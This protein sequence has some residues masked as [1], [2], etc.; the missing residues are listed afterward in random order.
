MRESSDD[1]GTS[2][3][4]V[5][6]PPKDLRCQRNDGKKWRCRDWRIH[7]QPYC[8]KHY[9]QLLKKSTV[10]KQNSSVSASNPTRVIKERSGNPKGDA[11]PVHKSGKSGLSGST[12]NRRGRVRA[13]DDEESSK[14]DEHPLK[15]QRTQKIERDISEDNSDKY[16]KN[17]KC[18]EEG[19]ENDAAFEEDVSLAK[20]WK[21]KGV[22]TKARAMDSSIM[23]K[24]GA[25]GSEDDAKDGK[26]ENLAGRSNKELKKRSE[27]SGKKE[28]SRKGKDKVE[29]KDG[30]ALG[31]DVDY[32]FRGMG[33]SSCKSESSLKSKN[34]KL[35]VKKMEVKGSEEDNFG[36]RQ[37]KKSKKSVEMELGIREKN[38]GLKGKPES[39]VMKAAKNKE[40]YYNDNLDDQLRVKQVKK[41]NR[42]AETESITQE[43]KSKG[44]KTQAKKMVGISKAEKIDSSGST[45][46]ETYGLRRRKSQTT[47][48]PKLDSRRKYY[49][50]DP[51]DP[52]MMCHQCMKS[53]RKVV[54]CRQCRPDR[55]RRYCLPCIQKWYPE[56]S[57]EDIAKA[58]PCCRQT[59]NCKDCLRKHDIP[60][61]VYSGGLGDKDEKTWYLKYLLRA[62]FS[63]LDEFNRDQMVEKDMEAKIRGSLSTD[64][65]IEKIECSRDERMYCD[66]CSTSIADFHRSCPNCSYD[67]CLTCCREIR[68][69]CLKGCDKGVV[70]QYTNRGAN[71][72]HGIETRTTSKKETSSISCIASHS[73]SE[74]MPVPEWKANVSGEIPCPP[75]EKGGCGHGTL[76][77][78]C[79]LGESWVSQLK[80]KVENLVVT[81]GLADVSQVPKQCPC[82]KINEGIAVNDEK[83]RKAASRRNSGDNYLF[84]PSA[85]DVH[86]G[87]LEH[88]QKHWIMGEPIIVSDVLKL[89]TGLS[90]DPM[91]MWRAFREISIKR[92]SSDLMVTAVDCLDSCEVDINI[93]Q[94]FT[95]YAE[96]RRD[97]RSWPE[98]LK[99]KDWPPSTLF[100]KRLPRHDAEFISALPYKEYTHPHS[101]ILNLAAKMKLEK[102]MLKPDLGPKTYI[103]YGFAEELGRGDSVTKLHCD[104]SDAVNILMHTADPTPTADQ[105]TKIE[106]LKKNHAAQDYKEL[107]GIVSTDHKE[108]GATVSSSDEGCLAADKDGIEHSHPIRDQIRNVD[109]MLNN[110]DNIVEDTD[111]LPI[112]NENNNL[113]QYISKES[114]AASGLLL[115]NQNDIDLTMGT[116]NSIQGNRYG[117]GSTSSDELC[118]K[119]KGLS[120]QSA[121]T[122]KNQQIKNLEEIDSGVGEIDFPSDLH[123]S[124]EEGQFSA[125]KSTCF[126][127][128]ST[129][130]DMDEGGA[131]WDIFR[132][133]DVPKLEQYLK[134]HHKEFRHI[135]CCPV[136]QVVHPIHDQSFYLTS[137]HKAKLK[138]E[139]G[140]EPW[141]FVQKLG[142]AIFIPAGCPHQ[143]RNLK[144]CI[145]VALDFVSPE[146]LSECVRLTKEFRVLPQNHRAKEDKLE[147]KKMALH[148][149]YDAVSELE[150]LMSC[151]EQEPELP[152]CG[153]MSH[154]N[155]SLPIQDDLLSASPC[156]SSGECP[157]STTSPHC[158]DSLQL[159]KDV[160]EEPTID[161]GACGNSNNI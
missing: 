3:S 105:L 158:R 33:K 72:F 55:P 71:Y 41:P 98:M 18:D 26:N 91:V 8:Q 118:I 104:M 121:T 35:Q 149:L 119:S 146:N 20:F 134:K 61:S 153:T 38:K 103:A 139:Y 67:L 65:K 143:V 116:R 59:C 30:D 27:F 16:D 135:Y 81:C 12:K 141:T 136:E 112:K 79:I 56:L 115:D 100:E 111:Q 25:S 13:E 109:T 157:T 21:T 9:L 42:N 53:D 63:F 75:K 159:S 46:D 108:A 24:E 133:Q 87:E 142:E 150:H 66:N 95:G 47:I 88:F 84:C 14:E 49:S 89:T 57:E 151:E 62:L 120:T 82:V 113:P 39:L 101:G 6:F 96:G 34:K 77:L 131:V 73:R 51:D 80:K 99:L 29:G 74:Q 52:C 17:V 106:K 23:L 147:V 126:K 160:P 37:V 152:V 117:T 68:E 110:V 76:E 19:K 85:S 154:P 155:P 36:V 70:I 31:Q 122:S 93:H 86:L 97:R 129:V 40:S 58:C 50:G 2:P 15:K 107:F 132:R 130:P 54:R 94:F 32:A 90:W 161:P 140:V 114:N 69:G 45:E 48:G 22:R 1:E 92:G 7:D 83:L 102:K 11:F 43:K 124:K 28:G 148:A 4:A 44:Q 127:F 64:I 128:S 144:S 60:E 156:Q 123:F 5:E 137:Y 145:K 78:K 138:E 10:L 125:G